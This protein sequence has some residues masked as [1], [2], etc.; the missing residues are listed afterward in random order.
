MVPM[1]NDSATAGNYTYISRTYASL[2]ACS[3][4]ASWSSSIP[5]RH[6][7]THGMLADMQP[8]TSPRTRSTRSSSESK[9]FSR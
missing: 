3:S 1:D 7:G 2:S 6:V 5:I 9:G 8:S 4:Y